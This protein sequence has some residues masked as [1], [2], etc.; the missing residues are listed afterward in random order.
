MHQQDLPV[1]ASSGRRSRR[2]DPEGMVTREWLRHERAWA[3]MH[4]ERSRGSSRGAITASCIAALAAPLGRIVMLSHVAEAVRLPG[5]R[6]I[7]IGGRERIG[8]APDAHGT[9]YLVE[10]RLDAGLPV[11]RYDVDGRSVIEKRAVPWPHMQNT[12]HCALT[13]C[14][15]G[16]SGRS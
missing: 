6:H 7:E 12:V 10:F 14:V 3:A 2:L 5:N 1:A 15:S 16:A 13:S 4:P 9:G 11:W 8:D